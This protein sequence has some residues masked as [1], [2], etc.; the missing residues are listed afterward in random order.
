MM[1]INVRAVVFASSVI[2]LA[3]CDTKHE[4][5][6]AKSAVNL[7]ASSDAP[8]VTL[9][10]ADADGYTATIAALAG[11]VV[12]VD[13]WATWC[14][15]CV[16]QFPHTVELYNKYKDRGLAVVSV[17]LDEPGDEAQVR[18]FLT[19]QGATFE[20]L[21]SKF[22]GGTQSTEAFGLPGP[23]PCYR[24]YD[25]TGKLVHEFAIDPRAA[26]QFTPQD[27][28]AVLAAAL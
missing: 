19:K 16:E 6:A 22:G 25:R 9:R 2:A 10:V 14:G 18:E 12:L 5:P 23:V 1:H 17:S 26:K 20:N 8:A 4:Q 27:I 24:I 28:E 13:F 15:P 7:A 11:K 21:L 3:G